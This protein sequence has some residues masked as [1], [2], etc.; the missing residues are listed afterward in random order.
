ME[1]WREVL[2][3]E[4]LYEISNLGR[5]RR[6]GRFSV[7]TQK[8]VEIRREIKP[9]FLK[10]F[11]DRDGYLILTLRK[12]GKAFPKKLHRLV[13][14]AFIS[15]PDN[16]PEVHHKDFDRG[17]ARADNLEWVDRYTN[18]EYTWKE[19][20]FNSPGRSHHKVQSYLLITPLNGIVGYVTFGRKQLQS[21]G[22]DQGAVSNVTRGITKSHRGFKFS[23]V[24]LHSLD[25]EPQTIVQSWDARKGVFV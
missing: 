18:L 24:S 13:A 23:R 21:L 3:F 20:G 17:N 9:M 25:D 6:L 10:H 7:F 12:S 22:F 11:K 4:G 8:G 16:L 1:V 15:N 19:T 14:E 2:G 5:V